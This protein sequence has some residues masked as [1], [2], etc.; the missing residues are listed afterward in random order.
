M[1]LAHLNECQSMVAWPCCFRSVT[2]LC[3]TPEVVAEEASY[4]IQSGGEEEEREAS[5]PVSS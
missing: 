2:A 3:I 4:V 1:S 5:A